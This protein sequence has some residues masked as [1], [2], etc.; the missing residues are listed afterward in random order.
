M[1]ITQEEQKHIGEVIY[2]VKEHIKKESLNGTPGYSWLQ[3]RMTNQYILSVM[4]QN[5]IYTRTA[6]LDYFN[7][8][9]ELGET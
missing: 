4:E 2:Y 8:L 7:H 5:D 3:E 6:L 1:A 9:I